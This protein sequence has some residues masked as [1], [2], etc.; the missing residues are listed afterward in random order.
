MAPT[1]NIFKFPFEDLFFFGSKSI[2]FAKYKST[3]GAVS[4]VGIP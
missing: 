1:V 3:K 4:S 2:T